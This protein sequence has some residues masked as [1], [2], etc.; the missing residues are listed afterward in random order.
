MSNAPWSISKANMAH[1]CTYRFH[2]RYTKRAKGRRIENSAGRIGTAVHDIL[3][4]ML[5]GTEFK[6][7]FVNASIQKLTRKE[8]LEL[9]THEE[10]I[11]RFIE[12]FADWRDK[13]GKPEVYPEVQMAITEELGETGYWDKDAYFRGVLDIST[14][15]TR[16]DQKYAVIIDH[17]TGMPSDIE[18]YKPQLDSYVAM[19]SVVYPDIVGAQAAIHWVRAQ[20]AADEEVI[21]WG[22]MYKR[23]VIEKLILPQFLEHLQSAE[24]RAQER[25]T[26]TEGWYC[27]FC[28]YQDSCP[29][30]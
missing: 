19:A 14:V 6:R 12:R 23:P 16:G 28:E 30:K 18:K 3:D 27:E 24:A 4:R 5:Q 7:A 15:V 8:I 20:E 29:I 11:K 26:P 10:G 2:M 22:P 17:K 13:M 1:E 25:P 21:A 9:K